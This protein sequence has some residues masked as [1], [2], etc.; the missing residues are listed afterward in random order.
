MS[1]FV[2]LHHTGRCRKVCVRMYV[3]ECK[4][5]VRMHVRGCV[6]LGRKYGVSNLRA[7]AMLALH[8]FDVHMHV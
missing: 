3:A 5:G 4:R 6:Q 1:E 2:L 8:V 7:V